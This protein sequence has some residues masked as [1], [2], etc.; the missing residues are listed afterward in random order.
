MPSEAAHDD[1]DTGISASNNN[2]TT[3]EG[4]ISNDKAGSGFAD[5][6][7]CEQP[8][9][10]SKGCNALNHPKGRDPADA[11]RRYAPCP[12]WLWYGRASNKP[13]PQRHDTQDRRDEEELPDLNA[14]IEK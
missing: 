9:F 4:T 11:V 6:G 3:S 7:E 5:G 10:I 12:C 1:A 8:F 14:N 13:S 2:R